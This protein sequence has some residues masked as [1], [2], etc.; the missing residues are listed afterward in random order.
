MKKILTYI[1]AFFWI[2]IIPVC[3]GNSVA[4]GLLQIYSNFSGHWISGIFVCIIS[5]AVVTWFPMPFLIFPLSSVSKSLIELAVVI[6]WIGGVFAPLIF[7]FEELGK[8]LL[9]LLLITNVITISVLET[10]L[11]EISSKLE[12][13]RK[14]KE[15]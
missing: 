8:I 12:M 3:I 1:Y 5:G 7:G 10:E 15:L 13:A 2:L 11:T 14:E 9:V 6:G 4:D